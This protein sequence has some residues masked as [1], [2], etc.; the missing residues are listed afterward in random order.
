MASRHFEPEWE[1]VGVKGLNQCQR[2]W[3]K[4]VS[5][6]RELEI[7]TS[8][9]N[10]APDMQM[11]PCLLTDGTKQNLTRGQ[12][13]QRETDRRPEKEIKGDRRGLGENRKPLGP[14]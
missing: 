4:H 8:T 14:P 11:S 7:Q 13:C 9:E 5:P 10:T 3:W 1:I 2:R 6:Q 12:S